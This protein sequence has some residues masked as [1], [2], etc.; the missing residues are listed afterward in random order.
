[1]ACSKDSVATHRC[2]CTGVSCNEVVDS[3]KLVVKSPFR[4]EE[5]RCPDPVVTVLVAEVSAVPAEVH[6]IKPIVVKW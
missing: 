5:E 6:D 4:D 2:D 1:M 3:A